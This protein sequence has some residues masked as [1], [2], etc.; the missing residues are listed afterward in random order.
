MIVA[1]HPNDT[2]EVQLLMSGVAYT[3][4]AKY[5]E[6]K[7]AIR[8]EENQTVSVSEIGADGKMDKKF[9]LDLKPNQ[10]L[11]NGPHSVVYYPGD[12]IIGVL[13]NDL[14][15]ARFLCVDG[16]WTVHHIE[17]LTG[18]DVPSAVTIMNCI[19]AAFVKFQE[20]LQEEKSK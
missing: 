6:T 10:H 14:V 3:Y 20:V 12:R 9:I 15:V 18:Y 7:I 4:S 16:E 11:E 13:S 1:L 8:Y 19:N 2:L 5:F 17:D